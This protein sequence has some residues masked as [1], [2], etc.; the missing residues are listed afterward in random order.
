M[1]TFIISVI[2]ESRILLLKITHGSIQ[3]LINKPEITLIFVKHALV[4]RRCV[5]DAVPYNVIILTL[6]IVLCVF[7]RYI[8]LLRRYD[9]AMFLE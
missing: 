8:V 2:M 4:Q 1:G 6:C 9:S 7:G 3:M 5:N